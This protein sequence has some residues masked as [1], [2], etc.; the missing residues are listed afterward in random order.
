MARSA[1]ERKG[2]TVSV[3]CSPR[4]LQLIVLTGL[5][6]TLTILTL[7]LI[8]TPTHVRMLLYFILHFESYDHLYVASDDSSEAGT[9]SCLHRL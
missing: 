9:H 1:E 5:S 2:R 6:L 7:A 4:S 8:L 3:L